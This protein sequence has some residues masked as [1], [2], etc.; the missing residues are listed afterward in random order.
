MQ[1]DDCFDHPPPFRSCWMLCLS[2]IALGLGPVAD[3]GKGR[4]HP[5]LTHTPILYFVPLNIFTC[6]TYILDSPPLT[7]PHENPA[8]VPGAPVN[9][10][11]LCQHSSPNSIVFAP[12]FYHHLFLFHYICIMPTQ[13]SHMCLWITLRCLIVCIVFFQSIHHDPWPQYILW[14]WAL[15]LCSWLVNRKSGQV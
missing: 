4:L 2:V 8:S 5:L 15:T 3:P 10:Y 6:C 9:L 1:N 13:E 7:P 14:C 12:L 11:S